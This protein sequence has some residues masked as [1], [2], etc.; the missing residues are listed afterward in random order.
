MTARSAAWT[1]SVVRAVPS[2]AAAASTSSVSRL[3]FVRLIF[4][5]LTS[6]SAY[7]STTLVDTHRVRVART[8]SVGVAGYGADDQQ[9]FR[10]EAYDMAAEIGRGTV[11]GSE[12]AMQLKLS[13][14][15]VSKPPVWRRLLVPA[16][17]RI[18]RLHDV[19]QTSMG[20]TDTHLHVF[21]TAAG[22]Y[23]VP[24]PELGFQNERNARLGQFLK[25]PGDRIQYAYDF[26]D[27]WEHDIVLEKHLDPDPE[28]QIPACL[29]G[30]GACPPEDCG[31]SWGY[32]DLKET[33]D[34]PRHADHA[35]M[36]DWLGLDSAENFDPAAC[37]LVEINEVLG[38]TVAAPRR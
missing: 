14:R 12:A 19:I 17:I 7:T 31:G 34:D 16:D 9:S 3:I 24:D 21:S 2:T 37:D 20:W 36:L 5:L 35:D 13:L 27:G 33:L 18:D 25:Q 6:P 29:A 30:K 28:A 32:A 10:P 8:G 11:N 26:G 15:G 4:V 1:V 22:D 38:M 23:G